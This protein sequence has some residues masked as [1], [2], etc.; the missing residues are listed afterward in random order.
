MDNTP[1]KKL[2][3]LMRKFKIPNKFPREGGAKIRA[4]G[5]EKNLPI[6]K[7]DRETLDLLGSQIKLSLTLG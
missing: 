7:F 6:S 2:D 3:P 5:G 4:R 1:P